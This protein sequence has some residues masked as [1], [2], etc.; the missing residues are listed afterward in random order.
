MKLFF[1]ALELEPSRKIYWIRDA[2]SEDWIQK[3]KKIGSWNVEI[4]H[5]V[6]ILVKPDSLCAESTTIGSFGGYQTELARSKFFLIKIRLFKLPVA[7]ALLQV[8][9]VYQYL[10]R[11]SH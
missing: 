1:G 7:L 2:T 8:I 3:F 6:E 4:W 10:A 11:V 9:P 5:D